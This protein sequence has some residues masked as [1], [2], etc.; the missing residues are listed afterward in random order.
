MNVYTKLGK[1]NAITHN[2]KTIDADKYI[3]ACGPWNRVLLPNMLQ[4]LTYISRQEVY[5]FS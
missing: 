2:E 4:K 1:N 3:I 5:Y